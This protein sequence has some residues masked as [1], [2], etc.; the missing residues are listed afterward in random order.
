MAKLNNLR[1]T[2]FAGWLA[3]TKSITK[4][5][6]ILE[7]MEW[8]NKISMQ[9]Y[10]G[11]LARHIRDVDITPLAIGW[12][13]EVSKGMRV[14]SSNLVRSIRLNRAFAYYHSLNVDGRER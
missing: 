14:M 11:V 1:F 6:K 4:G 10:Q 12:K 8:R 7:D 9:E 5:I 2:F 13:G 3:V